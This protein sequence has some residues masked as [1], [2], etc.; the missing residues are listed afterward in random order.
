MVVGRARPADGSRRGL[1]SVILPEATATA[2]ATA[3]D[4]SSAN[5]PGRS[6]PR[7]LTG[8][9]WRRRDA[10]EWA[11]NVAEPWHRACSRG[12]LLRS[13]TEPLACLP[14]IFP[15]TEVG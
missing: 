9:P 3:A 13:R 7:Q 12:L 11:L 8:R 1:S 5:Q 2:T 10:Q 15:V 6:T 14:E 4:A